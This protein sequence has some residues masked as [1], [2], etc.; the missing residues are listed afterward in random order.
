LIGEGVTKGED[1]ARCDLESHGILVSIYYGP[2][3]V[4]IIKKPT[5]FQ[6]E[7]MSLILTK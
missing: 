5:N 6:C 3:Q 4:S 7:K 2:E 1:F